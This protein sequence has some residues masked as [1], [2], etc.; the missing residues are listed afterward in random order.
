MQEFTRLYLEPFIA[1][2]NY[3]LFALGDA[4]I[5]PLSIIYLILLTVT[6]FFLS[7]KLKSLLIERVLG[8]TSMD[9]GARQAVGT[10]SRYVILFIGF[11]II[12]QTVGINLTTLN[13]LAGAVGIGVGFGLQ[14]IASNFISGLI[15]LF[16][17][18]I[19]IDDRVEVSGVEGR[20]MA[21]GARSTQVRTNDG[22]TLIVP[23]SKF[24]A[25][26]I[27]NWTFGTK[28]VRF[29]IPV[30]VNYDSDIELV[31][32]LLLQSAGEYEDVLEEPAS[33][34]QLLKFDKSSLNLELCVWT[35]KKIH[36]KSD[37][38]S[39]LN[40]LIVEK[41]RQNN[42]EIPDSTVSLE[43]QN[44]QLSRI[45]TILDTAKKIKPAVDN[46]AGT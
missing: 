7:N 3:N 25:E 33:S 24:I 17:R 22:I 23:N 40:F 31:K 29:R 13:V 9:I 1:A 21:I 2:L 41:F 26:S 18:P 46:E 44:E 28:L 32:K 6:L 4:K 20:V 30:A 5:T 42:V 45:K 35:E 16:E 38:I 27:V 15:I 14:N 12:L 10:I 43:I 36:N 34:V 11:L 19:K 37:L 39:D 8:R